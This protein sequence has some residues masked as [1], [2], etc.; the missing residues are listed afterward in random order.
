MCY[1]KSHLTYYSVKNRTKMISSDMHCNDCTR[2]SV[3]LL[4]RLNN[5]D[6][7]RI[8]MW[9]IFNLD[10]SMFIYRATSSLWFFWMQLVNHFPLP[11][12]YERDYDFVTHQIVT[13]CNIQHSFFNE[14]FTFG[15]AIQIEHQWVEWSE[16][17][18]NRF[19]KGEGDSHF[20]GVIFRIRI[21]MHIFFAFN[22]NLCS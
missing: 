21:L 7:V 13:A 20:S 16:A 12:E 10:C 15:L 9:D 17:G 5:N 1:E 11:T 3:P 19:F 14:W 6:R 18:P 22:I 4:T 8:W 2:I